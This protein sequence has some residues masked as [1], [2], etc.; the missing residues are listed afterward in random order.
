MAAQ[1]AD[2]KKPQAAIWK[3]V[4]AAFIRAKASAQFAD[5]IPPQKIPSYFR[6]KYGV[7]NLY[8]VDLAN[9]WRGFYTIEGR[10]VV[11]LDFVDHARYDAWFPNKGK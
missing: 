8:C 10:R 6:D 3:T 11:F 9:F 1:A 5:P 7:E 2:G 4:R